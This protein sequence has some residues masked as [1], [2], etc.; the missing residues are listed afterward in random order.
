M[1]YATVRQR[2]IHVKNPT[3]VIQ[4]G[5]GV[6]KLMLSM[7]EEWL[8]MDSIVC[9]FTTK[10]MVEEEKK[11]EETEGEQTGDTEGEE[12]EKEP[13]T[14]MVEKEE[15]NEM[16]YTF[17]EPV[18][19]PWENLKETGTL[20][21]SCT[22]YVGNEK[23][24]TTML[25]DSFWNVVQNGPMTGKEAVEP[26]TSLYDQI[27]AASGNAQ[28]AA[29]LANDV[30]VELRTAKE[31]GEF[32]GSDGVTPSIK[33]G[34]VLT[35]APG[36]E[37]QVTRKGTETEAIFD[38][39]IPRGAQGIQGVPGAPGA[40]GK[41]GTNGRDGRDGR[42]GK[43]GKDAEVT[44]ESITNALGYAPVDSSKAQI[45]FY[46]TDR[47]PV[48]GASMQMQ[49]DT[50]YDLYDRL[51]PDFES[52]K[53]MHNDLTDNNNNA[54][55][56][57]YVFSMGEYNEAGN[58]GVRDTDI[59]KPVVLVMSG[60]HGTE[61]AAVMS[62]YKFFKDFMSRKNIPA[63]IPEDAIFK[64]VPVVNP[65]GFDRLQDTNEGGVNLNRNFDY[66]WAP[67]TD[68]G[69]NYGTSAASEAETQ[70]IVKWLKENKDAI[71]LMDMH[72]SGN[73]TN[74]ADK[75]KEVTNFVG[76][77]N[78]Q[79]VKQAKKTA[80]RGV[81]RVIPYWR[82]V[83][84]YKP[85]T[86][87][88]YSSFVNAGGGCVYYAADTWKIPAFALELSR[89]QNG[90]TEWM[91]AETVSAGAEAIGNVLIEFVEDNKIPKLSSLTNVAE[92]GA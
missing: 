69:A 44:A 39:V 87:Y 45:A 82:N 65:Y 66:N 56:R 24:M 31:N 22:G 90:A 5:I 42:D 55:L 70:A 26:T 53:K 32:D 51:Y 27:I 86:I 40:P 52:G 77:N 6:D 80:L 19:V 3:T 16:L 54:V 91:T 2:K 15:V 61:K 50:V 14:I 84:K 8:D 60:I 92:V 36:S 33:V 20:S 18:L 43:D 74:N 72:G 57:E 34:N 78:N 68:A 76:L 21:V 25:P 83:I 89:M 59:K 37:A 28:T 47:E 64:V 46:F 4:N 63:N 13:T 29:K 73:K 81:G 9:V 1:L 58:R 38:F 75:F 67:A 49:T 30:A 23:V 85:D 41:N 79:I 7:D 88:A 71:L 48:P 62:T 11:E 10:Y 35:G 12:T 17:G